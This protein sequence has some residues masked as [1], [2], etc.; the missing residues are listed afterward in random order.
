MLLF[1]NPDLSGR[2]HELS[3]HWMPDDLGE[4]LNKGGQALKIKFSEKIKQ[5]L[6]SHCYGNVGILQKLTLEMLDNASIIEEKDSEYEFSDNSA[7]DSAALYY[8]DQLNP[9]YQQFARRVATGI[10]TKKSSTGI[11][12]HSMAV[13]MSSTDEQLINGLNVD[14]IFYLANKRQPIIQKGNLRSILEKLDGLQID[15]DGRG[16]VLTYNEATGDVTIIDKQ[17][18]LYRKFCTVK[19]P[20]EDLISE[21]D[22]RRTKRCTRRIFRRRAIAREYLV[23][24]K[25]FVNLP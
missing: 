19:W 24:L 1:L 13:I 12:A 7:L 20:W 4:V 21:V 15:T 23:V 16:L 5:N 6:I 25:D 8:A 11:Y 18:L 2:V 3:I 9:L 14:D 17:L 10:R 22:N